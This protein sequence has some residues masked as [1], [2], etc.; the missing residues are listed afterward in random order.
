MG[1]LVGRKI[2]LNE[3]VPFVRLVIPWR[4]MVGSLVGDF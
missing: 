1:C 4:C 3:D 2:E